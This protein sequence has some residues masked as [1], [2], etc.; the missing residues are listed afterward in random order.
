M[1]ESLW[2]RGVQGDH[3]EEDH[4]KMEDPQPLTTDICKGQKLIVTVQDAHPDLL[5]V[6]HEHGTHVFQGVLLDSTK[7]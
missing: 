4:D 6:S 3:G 5:L 2:S 7:G 1:S